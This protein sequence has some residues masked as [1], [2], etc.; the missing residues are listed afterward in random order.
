MKFIDTFN[1]FSD[2]MTNEPLP[3]AAQLLYYK[4]LNIWNRCG[5][6]DWFFATN[7]RL[8]YEII[9]SSNHTLIRNRDK[10]IEV[11]LIDFKPGKKGH[12]S[13]Y[14]IKKIQCSYDTINS[15][16]NGTINSTAFGTAFDTINGT[17]IGG[18]DKRKSK[19]TLSPR[20]ARD[21]NPAPNGSQYPN[22][23]QLQ[24]LLEFYSGINVSPGAKEQEILAEFA[25]SYT[26]EDVIEAIDRTKQR[27]PELVGVRLLYYAKAILKDWAVNG[28]DK[29]NK[30][31]GAKTN[32]GSKSVGSY[33]RKTEATPEDF[34]KI[35]G[36]EDDDDL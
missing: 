5:R 27:K 29:E 6:K 1:D 26:L 8:M 22:S 9:T 35:S 25:A 12:P 34:A 31:A 23:E 10:L 3:Q 36:W 13:K 30:N 14:K 28:K 24:Q 11:G 20:N 17:H 21:D 33:G 4:L 19:E 15:T 16:I 18:R 32:K 7:Q 2:L